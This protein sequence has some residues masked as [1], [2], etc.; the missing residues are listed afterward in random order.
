MSD[1]AYGVRPKPVYRLTPWLCR[2]RQRIEFCAR[3][4]AAPFS[5]CHSDVE[6]V[7]DYDG[8][9]DEPGGVAGAIGIDRMNLIGYMLEPLHPAKVVGGCTNQGFQHVILKQL[10]IKTAW[11]IDS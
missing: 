5:N 11:H 10:L 2:W 6:P 3:M 8:P 7:S 1:R 4:R 9:G